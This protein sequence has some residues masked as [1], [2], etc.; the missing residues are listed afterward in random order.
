MTSSEDRCAGCG[1]LVERELLKLSG[2]L[3]W[4][5]DHFPT[6]AT[7]GANLAAQ[8][9]AGIAA[10]L[11]LAGAQHVLHEVGLE[12]GARRAD[13]LEVAHDGLNGHEVKTER[14]TLFRLPEQVVAYSATCD[15][16]TAWVDERHLEKTLRALPD[17]WG[18]QVLTGYGPLRF[19]QIR[20]ALLNPSPQACATL[21][22]LWKEEVQGLA[23]ELGRFYQ[24][25]KWSRERL[26]RALAGEVPAAE[27]RPLVRAAILMRSGWLSERSAPRP[28][29]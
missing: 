14:D 12:Y 1:C 7:C 25:S 27:L 29:P 16:C 11:R 10:V 13:L 21:R 8:A 23:R 22:L 3:L 18:L 26:S 4:C 6:A 15:R 9:H 20:P 5:A 2:G 24:R 19:E 17:W 28:H